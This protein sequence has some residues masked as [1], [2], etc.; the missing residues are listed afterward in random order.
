MRKAID[1]QAV[2]KTEDRYNKRL[3]VRVAELKGEKAYDAKVIS[4]LRTR[5]AKA[6]QSHRRLDRVNIE[7]TNRITELEKLVESHL[8]SGESVAEM[9]ERWRT[10]EHERARVGQLG[11]RK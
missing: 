4:Q 5:V 1:L 7:Q 8:G 3:Q 9:K 2:F 11:S 10:E 6:E